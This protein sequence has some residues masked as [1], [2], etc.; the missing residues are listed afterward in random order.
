MTL[1]DM[2]AQLGSMFDVP[3]A[4]AQSYVN[5]AY[6]SFVADSEWLTEYMAFGTTVAGQKDYPI[7]GT[8]AT[9]EDL[10]VGGAEYI[11]GGEWDVPDLQTGQ[12][13]LPV[14]IAGAYAQSSSATGGDQVT[15]YPT[16]A[17]NGLAITAKVVLIPG[18]LN[19]GDTPVV[20]ADLHGAILNGAIAIAYS[21]VDELAYMSQYFD[22]QYQAGIQKARGRKIRRVSGHGPRRAR[23]AGRDW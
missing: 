3:L 14:G 16:P 4:T 18:D 5:E 20:P 1:D 2:T 19:T 7:P 15:L 22:G 12:A 8:V 10:K 9:I 21:R 13:T 6:K 17:S 11:R 23:V